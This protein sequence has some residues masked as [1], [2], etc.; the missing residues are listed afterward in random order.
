M[1]EVST[2]HQEVNTYS[3]VEVKLKTLIHIFLARPK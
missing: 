3:V 2:G 1:A